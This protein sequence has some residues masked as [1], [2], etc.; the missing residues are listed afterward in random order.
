MGKKSCLTESNVCLVCGSPY[1]E[2]HHVFFGT[3]N[4]RLS[5]R[6]GYVVPLCPTHHRE[7]AYSAHKSRELDMEYKCMAQRHFEEHNGSR[8]DF[9]R[10]FGRSYL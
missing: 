9:I 2:I 3:A 8:E 5:D 1:I 4:R 6:Y 10:I 7:G